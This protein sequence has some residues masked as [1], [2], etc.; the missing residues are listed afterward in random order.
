MAFI[1]DLDLNIGD[2]IRFYGKI[3]E[4][5]PAFNN[6]STT[7]WKWLKKLEGINYEMKGTVITVL[8]GRNF[9]QTLRNKLKKTIEDSG[10]KQQDVIKALTIG[11]KTSLNENTINLFLK[12]GTSHIL[13]IS[14]LH[15]GII[16]GF[17]F[18]ILCWLLGR[19][20]TLKLSGRHTKYASL[21]TIPFPFIFMIISGSSVS[22]I[23]ATIMITVFMLS[24]FFEK[25]REITNTIA[26]SA[27]II[28]LIYP[29]SLF[30]PSFQLSFMSVLFIVIIMGKLYP[31][32]KLKNTYI[33]WLSTSALTTVAATIGTLPIVIYHFYGIN[34]FCMIHNIISIPVMCMVSIP[35]SF[36]G[37]ILPYGWY[38]LRLAG[39]LLNLNIAALSYLDI[40]YIFP[41]IRPNLFEM[42]LFYALLL[43]IIFFKKKLVLSLLIIIIIPLTIVQI[44]IVCKDRFNNNISLNFIDVG[45][46]E[47]ILV[48]AP[49]G[50]R[51]L[52]DAGGDFRGNFDTGRAI[53]TPILLSRK[54]LT[55]D[56]VINTHPHSD[57]AGGIPYILNTFKV[58]TFVT[59]GYYSNDS[60]FMEIHKIV[61]DKKINFQLWKQGNKISIN[62]DTQI[63]VMNPQKDF[64]GDDLN[65][66]SLVLK[67]I[68][69][70][71]SFLLTG[72]IGSEVEEKLILS[73]MPLASKIM[74]IPHHGSKHSSSP[75]FLF[76]V[77]PDIAILSV[78]SGIKGL[79]SEEAIERYKMLSIPVLRT[80]KNGFIQISSD[81][82]RITGIKS[83]RQ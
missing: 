82:D 72:D 43:C 1:T 18:F 61:K 39:E 57:H 11:D 79:P 12:T 70:N 17:F 73:G 3:R 26:L 60:A 16:T 6:P 5:S 10:A 23:R 66:S 30:M 53:V 21:M 34:P 62:N 78:G 67:F 13:A 19:F 80:D 56:Y 36:S 64:Q 55:L 77:K 7:S 35:V 8:P 32:I 38:L 75:P 47:A 2:K 76:A 20:R 74:K 65:N 9:I 42:L 15:V 68:Y 59:G 54:I 25:Q 58:K 27:L 46:G 40:G 45:I 51:M 37:M 50:I 52:I 33:K 71:T 48:E 24:L 49:K 83:Y 44:S 81:G 4:L 28:L 41:I 14:G 22:T 63:L 29:H 31:Y 69:K